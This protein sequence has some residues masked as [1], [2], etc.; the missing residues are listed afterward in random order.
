VK[1]VVAVVG[2]EVVLS[3]RWRGIR[4]QRTDDRGRRAE[5]RNAEF[6]ADSSWLRAES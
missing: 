4:N 5:L 1:A 3:I 2:E 6:L